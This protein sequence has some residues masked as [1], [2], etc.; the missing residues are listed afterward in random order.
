MVARV[1]QKLSSNALLRLLGLQFSSLKGNPGRLMVSMCAAVA[2]FQKQWSLVEQREATVVEERDRPLTLG[3]L[4]NSSPAACCAL[5]ARSVQ[6][7]RHW[8]VEAT[9]NRFS[10]SAF[11][12]KLGRKAASGLG[13]GGGAAAIHGHSQEGR[14]FFALGHALEFR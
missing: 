12:L 8:R 7:H 6:I 1:E 3:Y 11:A 9:R 4:R 14:D 13:L 2:K 10:R 5:F